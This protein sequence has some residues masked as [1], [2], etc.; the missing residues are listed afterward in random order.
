MGILINLENH[1][2]EIKETWRQQ[3]R[4][5]LAT[6]TRMDHIGS[7]LFLPSV[8][9]DFDCSPLG[10]S[11]TFNALFVVEVVVVGVFFPSA[12]TLMAVLMVVPVLVLVFLAYL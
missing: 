11:L 4:G 9:I 7:V 6:F 8:I 12:V 1:D 10:T 2:F 5:D 3:G